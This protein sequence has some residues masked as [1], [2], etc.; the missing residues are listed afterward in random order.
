MVLY[1]LVQVEDLLLQVKRLGGKLNRD[2]AVSPPPMP[3]MSLSLTSTSVS[4]S[5]IGLEKENFILKERIKLMEE[6]VEKLNCKVPDIRRSS[7]TLHVLSSVSIGTIN[8]EL[9]VM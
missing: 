7:S 4:H 3:D 6:E 2:K 9:L 5:M 8:E 1:Y